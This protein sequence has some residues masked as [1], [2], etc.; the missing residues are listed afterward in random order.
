MPGNLEASLV[1]WADPIVGQSY[2]VAPG[3]AC[4]MAVAGGHY[5]GSWPRRVI[6]FW[7]RVP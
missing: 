7:H 3:D 6:A 1:K 5:V 4:L 2:G